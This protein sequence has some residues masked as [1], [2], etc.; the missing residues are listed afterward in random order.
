MPFIWIF[1][2]YNIKIEFYYSKFRVIV[3]RLDDKPIEVEVVPTDTIRIMKNKLQQLYSIIP[4]EHTLLH[5]GNIVND[6]DSLISL[7]IRD[8]CQMNIVPRS[9]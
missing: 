9:R 8:S 3:S 7:G 1:F 5:K 4:E 2:N 6:D